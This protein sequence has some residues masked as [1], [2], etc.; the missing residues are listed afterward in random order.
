M[1]LDLGGGFG[2]GLITIPPGSLRLA[3]V[4]RS[5]QRVSVIKNRLELGASS[6]SVHIQIRLKHLICYKLVRKQSRVPL[7]SSQITILLVAPY[8]IIFSHDLEFVFERLL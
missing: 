5:A 4:G 8:V 6:G 7:L 3:H 2:I 1:L